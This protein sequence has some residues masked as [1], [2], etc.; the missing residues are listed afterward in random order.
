MSHNKKNVLV[1]T[2]LAY[3]LLKD[4]K[5][6][7]FFLVAI[8][9]G[10]L[11]WQNDFGKTSGIVFGVLL[12]SAVIFSFFSYL[13]V[14]AYRTGVLINFYDKIRYDADLPSSYPEENRDLG[15]IKFKWRG[16]KVT[17]ISVQGSG[18]SN[19]VRS[20]SAWRNIKQSAI[21]TLPLYGDMLF[22][23]FDS[24]SRGTLLFTT[25]DESLLLQE[26]P[27]HLQ[28]QF[29]EELHTLIYDTLG[30]YNTPLPVVQNLQRSTDNRGNLIPESFEIR[31]TTAVSSYDRKTFE[32]QIRAKYN[33]PESLWGF[34][35][36]HTNVNI[37]RISKG[38]TE[39]KQLTMF[40]ALSNLVSNSLRKS[41]FSA[42]SDSYNF[43]PEMVN[44]NREATNITEF[45][46]DFLDYD[47]SDEARREEFEKMVERGLRQML[48]S[49]EWEFE[50]TI[51]I[52]GNAL[53]VRN[54]D[55]K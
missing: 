3:L 48:N 11:W 46:I 12:A 53:T 19:M 38:S 18:T 8:G 10:G 27:S 37:H 36:G 16:M 41:F 32:G 17:A 49:H 21:D 2:W 28:W 5:G 13:L 22:A 51:Q 44:M 45:S 35:W 50:W 42:A 4:T 52:F 1:K 33:D 40:S 7:F 47:L 20:T 26:E 54:L 24:H 34:K 39:E 43:T 30:S 55:I 9:A 29:D 31:T 25:A 23:I 6:K 15:K 14:G